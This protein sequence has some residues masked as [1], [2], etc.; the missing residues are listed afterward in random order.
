MCGVMP[1][2]GPHY[3]LEVDVKQVS[4]AI[5]FSCHT[6][7]ITSQLK[8]SLYQLNSST[9]WSAVFPSTNHSISLCQQLKY[10][11][12]LYGW[13]AHTH[14]SNFKP[15]QL[16]F[17]FIAFRKYFSQ[18][19]HNSRPTKEWEREGERENFISITC[20]SVYLTSSILYPF[21]F[22]VL[23][24]ICAHGHTVYIKEPTL[25]RSLVCSFNVIL[26]LYLSLLFA[27]RSKY[28]YYKVCLMYS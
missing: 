4:I 18:Y 22:N 13:H 23:L 14:T 9:I 2:F 24:Y 25:A 15:V 10:Y 1:A 26:R 20:S 19:L 6:S 16:D 17:Q 5:Q 27:T 12:V 11:T 7:W 3:Y 28:H 21:Y 8:R